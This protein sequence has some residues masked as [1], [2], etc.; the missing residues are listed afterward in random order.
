MQQALRVGRT[1]GA[2]VRVGDLV[3]VRREPCVL[4]QLP[5]GR[6]GQCVS[7]AAS[8]HSVRHALGDIGF[9]ASQWSFGVEGEASKQTSKPLSASK[10]HTPLA[11]TTASDALLSAARIPSSVLE[12]L[13]RFDTQVDKLLF[14]HRAAFANVHHHFASRVASDNSVSVESVARFVFRAE[15]SSDPLDPVELCAAHVYLSQNP[16]WFRQDTPIATSAGLVMHPVFRLNSLEDVDESVWLEKQAKGSRPGKELASFLEKAKV[17]IEWAATHPTVDASQL[18]PEASPKQTQQPP[19]VEF[20]DS[21]LKFIKAIK[22]AA[23]HPASMLNPNPL[24]DLVNRGILSRLPHGYSRRP[25]YRSSANGPTAAGRGRDSMRLLKDLGVVPAWENTSIASAKREG[26]ALDGID[27]H[28]LSKW[29]DAAV[30]E[31]AVWVDKLLSGPTFYG[32][33][34]P[35][36]AAPVTASDPAESLTVTSETI[37]T[38]SSND[39]KSDLLKAIMER[40]V[41]PET[42]MQDSFPLRDDCEAIRRDFGDMPV[43]VIDSPTAHELDDGISIEETP[44]G[45]WMH[46]HIADPT[47]YLPVGHP[48]S[49]LA[50]LRGNSLYLPE[51]HYPML[52]DVL[53]NARFNLGKSHCALTFSCRLGSDGEI[54]DYKITPSIVKNIRILHYRTV[55]RVLDWSNVYGV[56]SPPENLMPW[57]NKALTE[58]QPTATD[59][60]SLDPETVTNLRKLQQFAYTHLQ[61][62]ISRGGFVS[63]QPDMSVKVE[64]Y[65]L[66]ITPTHPTHAFAYTSQQPTPPPLVLLDANHASHIE[67]SSNL[68]SECMIMANRVAAKFC[69]DRALPAVY[70]GQ[71]PL[72]PVFGEEE[73]AM[74]SEALATVDPV[75]GVLA[76]NSFRRILPYFSGAEVSMTPVA[77]YMLGV[78]GG[79]EEFGGYMKVTSPL[80]RY[81]DLM[82]HWI[83]KGSLLTGAT[84]ENVVFQRHD[85]ERIAARGFDIEKRTG[86][87]SSA[88]ARFWALEWILRR[89]VLW[90]CGAE[91]KV[92]F[93]G[94]AGEMEG[95]KDL[96]VGLPGLGVGPR[97][98][99]VW[100]SEYRGAV[101]WGQESKEWEVGMAQ[102]C[103]QPT[104]RLVL[105]SVFDGQSGIGMLGDLGG[106]SARIGMKVPHYPGDVILCVVDSVD[107]ASG[108]LIMREL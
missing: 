45:T 2:A 65:P 22:S 53:S 87:V 28:G 30:S 105:S 55:N 13:A 21:D 17:L 108:V 88:G 8:G 89:E 103:G 51:R 97:G 80:R 67:P 71:A 70:R 101:E 20:S 24:T 79:E 9:V 74:V 93:S 42:P 50:Q 75:S 25:V 15:S 44:E 69:T 73:R 94:V 40:T 90:R 56:S 64:P 36:D 32:E 81:K 100:S 54:C 102:R 7:I 31:S 72:K 52:P 84:G 26:G 33:S 29:A 83:I 3:Q 19:R 60:P 39:A 10:P 82:M 4:A 5:T 68:V 16:K 1:T 41:L 49:M 92:V 34:G 47:A 14:D 37:A 104:F 86:K 46:A 63:D 59:A 58:L 48:L 11:L 61:L 18:N 98:P 12:H 57:V 76:Y 38:A 99:V 62:R 27:G 107:P 77:H 95:L 78:R 96:G 85:V 35:A 23:F 91:E 66:P 43:Y 106:V 6:D